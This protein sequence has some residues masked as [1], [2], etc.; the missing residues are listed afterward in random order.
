MTR[1]DQGRSR[2]LSPQFRQLRSRLLG[3]I[4]AVLG[5]TLGA[6]GVSTYRLIAQD[7]YN[8]LDNELLQLAD[9]AAH[10]LTEGRHAST[11][12]EPS[13]APGPQGWGETPDEASETEAGDDDE[14]APFRGPA[15]ATD[16]DEYVDGDG[17]L[18]LP[19]QY[20]RQGRRRLEWFDPQGNLRYA[21]GDTLAELPRFTPEARIVQAG[22]YRLATVPVYPTGGDRPLGYVRVVALI[23]PLQIQLQ[24]LRQGFWLGGMVAL[25]LAGG[26]SWLLMRIVMQPV[27]ASFERLRQFTADASHELRSPLTVIQTST[28]VMQSHPDRIH[29]A[30]GKKLAAI[31]SAT[32]QMGQLVEDLLLLA[33]LDEAGAGHLRSLPLGELLGELAELWQVQAEQRHLHFIADL[34]AGQVMGDGPQL[35]RLFMNL[36]DNAVKYTP[37]G[38]TITL[39]ARR[40]GPL[41]VITVQDTGPGIA[42]EH[43]TKVFDRFWRADTAR[44]PQRGSGL[45]LAIARSIAQSHRG[46][47]TLHSE[48]GQGTTA[49][50]QLPVAG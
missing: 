6:A 50:V 41:W 26:G 31:A 5:L 25:V 22:D 7:L 18:D 47:L 48:V 32:R 38:G 33:R 34:C 37:P 3:A 9:V 49:R 42:P 36:L 23:R 17:D 1:L 46:R 19:W 20:L 11:Q 27:E 8:R 4:L 39:Q 45:G 28:A 14:A 29:P 10:E 30:D 2:A 24:Q 16:I 12:A 15:P 40:Q 43:L 44:A 35:R 13:P 21:A